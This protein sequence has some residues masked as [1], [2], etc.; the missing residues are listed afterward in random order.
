[1]KSLIHL[2]LTAREGNVFTGVCHSVHNRPYG[3]S[4]TAHA[5]WLLGHCY[6]EV[7]MHPTGMHSCFKDFHRPRT[8]C[9]EHKSKLNS[10]VNYFER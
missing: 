2:L 3:H 7:G 9:T 8:L 1:M 6:G 4:V 5:C 10:L